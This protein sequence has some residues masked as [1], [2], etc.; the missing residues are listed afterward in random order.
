LS[1][2]HLIQL[3]SA[4]VAL[5]DLTLM[6]LVVEQAL[7]LLLVLFGLLLVVLVAVGMEA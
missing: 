3:P 4:Q 5:A 1:Q 2:E 6:A 7:L